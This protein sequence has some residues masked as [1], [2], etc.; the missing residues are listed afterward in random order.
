MLQR[1]AATAGSLMLVAVWLMVM[2][3]LTGRMN[4]GGIDVFLVIAVMTALGWFFGLRLYL[5]FGR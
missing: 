2:A 3:R 5:R 1:T 4:P